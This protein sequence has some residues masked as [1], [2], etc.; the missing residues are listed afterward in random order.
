M[1]V[2]LISGFLVLAITVTAG[3]DPTVPKT[4]LPKQGIVELLMEYLEVRYPST[5]VKGDLLYVSVHQQSMFHVRNGWLVKEYPIA[6]AKNGL[7]SKKDSYRTPTGMHR[8]SEK[9]G[10][11]VPYLGIF[12]DRKF[13]GEIADTSFTGADLDHI[14]SRILRLQGSEPGHNQGGS[15]DS[16]QR[17]IYIHGT[18]NEASI[19]KPSSRGCIRMR[20]AD[21]I[22]LYDLVQIGTPVVILDN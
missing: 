10:D 13:T 8:I 3:S 14:T 16:H 18:A 17:F 21:V 12:K 11:N 5:Y 19:G 2:L 15:I 1:R 7:G 22:E 20:N 9:F 4:P 6:T